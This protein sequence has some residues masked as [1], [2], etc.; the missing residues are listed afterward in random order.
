M[1]F[2]LSPIPAPIAG[3]YAA[4]SDIEDVF[5][6]DNVAIWSQLNNDSTGPDDVRLL[7][8]LAFADAAIDDALRGGPYALPLSA[9]DGSI[10]PQLTN[11]AATI[12]G[13]WLYQSR[14]GRAGDQEAT[15]YAQVL[16][17]IYQQ[18]ALAKSGTLHLDAL[19]CTP[20]TP[21]CP[22]LERDP[23]R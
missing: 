10:P 15:R 18:I 8:P 22:T 14:G 11:W 17:D 1:P 19:C 13:I 20:A 4:Q 9:A 2:S 21:N 12:A 5:G 7:K 16:A 23:R 6:C 3:R